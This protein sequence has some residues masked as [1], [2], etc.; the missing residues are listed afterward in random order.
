MKIIFLFVLTLSP[1]FAQEQSLIVDITHST[2]FQQAAEAG[3]GRFKISFYFGEFMDFTR[4]KKESEMKNSRESYEKDLEFL[5]EREVNAA[6]EQDP[7]K[8]PKLLIV[9]HEDVYQTKQSSSYS[10]LVEVVDRGAVAERVLSQFPSAEVEHIEVITSKS[11]LSNVQADRQI[12]KSLDLVSASLEGAKIG[13]TFMEQ[14]QYTPGQVVQT[15]VALQLLTLENRAEII[16][17]RKSGSIHPHDK[18][19][20]A[21]F[22]LFLPQGKVMPQEM[23]VKILHSGERHSHSREGR[24]VRDRM[25]ILT[26][27]LNLRFREALEQQKKLEKR[28]ARLSTAGYEAMEEMAPLKDALV[29]GKQGLQEFLVEHTALKTYEKT[30]SRAVVDFIDETKSIELESPEMDTKLS[31]LLDNL[32]NEHSVGIPKKTMQKILAQI[33]NELGGKVRELA[34]MDRERNDIQLV[35]EIFKR[36]RP[37]AIEKMIREEL[38]VASTEQIEQARE[39]LGG[40]VNIGGRNILEVIN[41]HFEQGRIEGVGKGRV[42]RRLIRNVDPASL[43]EKVKLVRAEVIKAKRGGGP[44]R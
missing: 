4:G 3:P 5:L 42:E 21:G 9:F 15:G 20:R 34:I 10:D 30:V 11:N 27:A 8:K 24:L 41:L 39:Q 32:R 33:R 31:E 14:T 37:E 13:V 29:R 1:L 36:T 7:E 40:V 28:D 6:I 43:I 26:D 22:K 17:R 16:L 25:D 19:R 35:L 23:N 18:L 2:P 12:P 44:R 38:A